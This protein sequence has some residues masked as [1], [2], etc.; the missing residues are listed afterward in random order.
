[1]K[2]ACQRRK[3]RNWGPGPA[4]LVALAGGVAYAWFVRPWHLEWGASDAESREDLPGDELVQ[5]ARAQSTRAI[6]IAAPAPDV[7]AWLVQIGQN[8]G[9]FYSYTWLENLVGCRM[10]NADCIMPNFQQLNLGDKVWL[11]PNA[12]PLP[13]EMIVPEEALVLGSNTRNAGTWAFYLREVA[14]QTTR[15]IVRSRGDWK[16][17]PFIWFGHYV[18]FEPIH[19]IME[20]KMMFGIKRRAEAAF[21]G[22]CANAQLL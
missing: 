3:T 19:F 11:H 9:G 20:R 10:R 12:P 4:A 17:N 8:K 21:R 13:V 5:H 16:S 15:L 7:W 14:P 2:N 18:L 6:T 22:Q 1:M